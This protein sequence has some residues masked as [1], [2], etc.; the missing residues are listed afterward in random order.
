[1]PP[2]AADPFEDAHLKSLTR[3]GQETVTG[4][5][6]ARWRWTAPAGAGI[7]QVHGTWG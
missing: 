6:F 5:G 4:T 1:V 2:A 7:T 3:D